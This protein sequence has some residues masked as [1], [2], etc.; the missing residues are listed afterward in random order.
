MFSIFNFYKITCNFSDYETELECPGKI[1]KLKFI[2]N[3]FEI[4]QTIPEF[5]SVPKSFISI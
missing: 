3:Q 2:P 5:V 1:F 4:F